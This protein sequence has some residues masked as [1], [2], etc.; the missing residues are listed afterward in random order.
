MPTASSPASEPTRRKI[1]VQ[2]RDLQVLDVFRAV[3]FADTATL[4]AILTPHPF[5][6]SQRLRL[7]LPKL[8]RLG[9]IDRPARRITVSEKIEIES[10]SIGRGRPQDI[11]ALAQKGADVLQMPGDWNR[12]NGRLR[13]GA[14]AH[15]L[16]IA[17]IFAVL[18]A[19]AVKGRIGIE[20]WQGENVFR[21]RVAVNGMV[22]PVV[23][24]ATFEIST[25]ARKSFRAFLEV[26]N[27]TEPLVRRNWDQSSFYKKCVAYQAYWKRVL[28]PHGEGAIVVLTVART[29][30]AAERLRAT[31]ARV[32]DGRQGWNLFWFTS[33]AEMPLAEPERF[34]FEPIWTTGGGR[35]WSI[36]PHSQA[37]HTPSALAL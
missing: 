25:P 32:D 22:L 9:L 10:E 12:N 34:L 6:N 2:K 27:S 23:P 33:E 8:Q 37:V 28:K 4:A 26:D 36:F 7:R 29:A 3:R 30:E 11:W 13:P 24:D 17:R 19:A 14:F 1:A 18:R 20:S 31:A 5:P 16:T 35:R 21:D 15:P